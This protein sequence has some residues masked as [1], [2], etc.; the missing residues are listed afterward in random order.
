MALYNSSPRRFRS[1]RG[2]ILIQVAVILIALIA[3]LSFVADYGLMW[4]S[5]RQ[6][7]N[8][9][10]AGA[11]AG[12]VALGLDDFADR[13]DDG[14]AKQAAYNFATSNLVAGES[15]D[16][17]MD[18]D[19]LFYDDDPTKFPSECA[20]DSCIRVDVYRNQDRLN[21]LP[22][23][24]GQLLGLQSQG[25]RAMA[26][27]QAAFGN[28]TD[29]LKPWA[30]VDKWEENWEDGALNPNSWEDTEDP[31]FDRYNK[32]GDLDTTITDPDVYTPASVEYDDEGVPQ[33]GTYEAGTGFHPFTFNTDGTV[34][35]YTED[36]G[37][38]ISLKMGDAGDWNFGSGWFMKLDFEDVAPS[39]PMGEGPCY[40]HA[41][42]HCIGTTFQ[43]GDEVE[44]QNSPG[45][46]DGPTSSSVGGP[47]VNPQ[48]ADSLYN[49]DPGAYWDPTLN[50]DRGG[51]A[52]SAFATSPRIVAVPLVNPDA[53]MQTFKD[54]RT[55]VPISNIA[56]FFVEGV[57]GHGVN[58]TVV[59]RLMTIPGL[60]TSGS[61]GNAPSTFM[62]NITLV[63]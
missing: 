56:G 15:P 18:T 28:A 32:D 24:F 36:Y 17:Q 46:M 12:A 57:I 14:P 45:G 21:P 4:V 9:A 47:G 42:K 34:D 63:R 3:F 8:A 35:S 60:K 10:D 38:Q 6:A 52:G 5:R 27:A 39:C 43:I 40:E 16:V 41:I 58:Q 48:D 62:L 50:G 51:V 33:W 2:A 11:L 44:I 23:W 1:E 22:M 53:L 54:G 61:G 37:R 26:I 55:T 20:D 31:N 49:Q 29:C 25:V 19:I 59:G 7:Q 30:V 13:T